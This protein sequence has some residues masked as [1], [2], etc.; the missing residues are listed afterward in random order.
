MTVAAIAEFRST[1]TLKPCSEMA[2]SDLPHEE[3]VILETPNV[4]AKW[5]FLFLT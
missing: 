1:Y 5:P 4:D 2:F 3:A